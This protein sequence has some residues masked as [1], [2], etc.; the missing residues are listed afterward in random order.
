VIF[1]RLSALRG[2]PLVRHTGGSAAIGAHNMERMVHCLEAGPSNSSFPAS[3]QSGLEQEQVESVVGIVATL[4]IR[5]PASPQSGLE[6]EQ[7]ES[8][9][10]IVATLA[11]RSR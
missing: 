8:V 2:E 11:I 7:V 5:S 6:Q 9:V 1:D 3:P 10:G 4:A